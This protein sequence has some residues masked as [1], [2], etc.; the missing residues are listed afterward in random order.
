M[1]WVTISSVAFTNKKKCS[2]YQAERD[3]AA[4]QTAEHTERC[5]KTPSRTSSQS[6]VDRP[7]ISQLRC[8]GAKLFML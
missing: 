4:E 1:F 8:F 6:F 7:L 5:E 2:T 3:L